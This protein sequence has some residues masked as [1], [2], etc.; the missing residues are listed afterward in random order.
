MPFGAQLLFK[1]ARDGN[2][3][4][5][6]S[7]GIMY[8][9]GVSVPQNFEEARRWFTYAS[10]HGNS[11]AEFNLGLT[12]LNGQGTPVN[13][14][15][16]I[17]LFRSAADHGNGSAKV[18]LAMMHRMGNGVTQDDNEAAR[19]AKSA[20]VQGYGPG[21]ALLAIYYR[22]GRGVPASDILSYEWAS[23]AEV[24]ITG[25]GAATIRQVRD[26]AAYYLSAT[27]M[28][29]AQTATAKWKN[30]DDLIAPADNEPHSP[31]VRG[32]GSGIVVGKNHEILT[33]DHVISACTEIHIRDFAGNENFIPRVIARD[34]AADV[35][36]LTG[37]F[38]G[39]LKLRNTDPILGETVVTFGYPLTQILSSA[40][41]LTNG[42]VSSTA[43]IQG[44]DKQFQ[45]S[46]AV[47]PGSSGG[48]VVDENGTVI[49]IIS[50]GLN[51]FL[52][53]ANTGTIP[54]NV[55]FASK[56]DVARSLMDRNAISYEIGG[57]GHSRVGT[58]LASQLQRATVKIECWR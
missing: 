33:D 3:D 44:N 43:G 23:L 49:G 11:A 22:D 31:K 46:A 24:R 47:Q 42:T 53:A 14:D 51:P 30:G 5:A 36:L 16:A 4:A 25:Q 58:E 39:A 41:N 29:S 34:T 54:Q 38:G 7:V 12:Y 45:I 52:V 17:K 21:Q 57:P 40:G 28:A 18:Q 56:M 35:A 26:Q 9:T 1:V 37:S 55:S 10:G 20:A 32:Y 48:P 27:E 50:G 15:E 2:W 19:L 13:K 6:N 8:A